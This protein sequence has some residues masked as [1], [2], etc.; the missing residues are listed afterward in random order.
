[1][2]SSMWRRMRDQPLNYQ[3]AQPVIAH[4]LFRD[5][6]PSPP[7]PI[8]RGHPMLTSY[9]IQELREELGEHAPYLEL[10]RA[11]SSRPFSISREFVESDPLTAVRLFFDHLGSLWNEISNPDGNRA[12]REPAG[13]TIAVAA[14]LRASAVAADIP[15][16]HPIYATLMALEMGA[17]LQTSKS[18]KKLATR[19]IRGF[20][21]SL[22]EQGQTALAA[23]GVQLS[24]DQ[25]REIILP[26]LVV[27]CSELLPRGG[28]KA[29][30]GISRLGARP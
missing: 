8:V 24:K 12:L 17:A 10:V 19:K 14:A 23:G 30:D 16:H 22:V 20:T 7:I 26:S 6:I 3:R 25:I 15:A 18:P 1:M 4:Q 28:V 11:V 9:A 21:V 13:L 27:H 5:V 2:K 29:V